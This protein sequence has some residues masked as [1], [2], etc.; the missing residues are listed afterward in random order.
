MLGLEQAGFDTALFR[1][2]GVR[3]AKQLREVLHNPDVTH[4]RDAAANFI[5][6][7]LAIVPS[8]RPSTAKG[9][10]HCTNSMVD[11]E[12]AKE[13]NTKLCFEK[14]SNAVKIWKENWNR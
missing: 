1:R 11:S 3:P 10:N 14:S 2:P 6:R 12:L 13:T 7:L 9:M 5:L 4:L 8:E